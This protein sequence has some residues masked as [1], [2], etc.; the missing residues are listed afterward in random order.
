VTS[1]R[2]DGANNQ[3]R[4]EK[5]AELKADVS[6]KSRDLCGAAPNNKRVE[7][8]GS[9]KKTVVRTA[10]Y[11]TKEANREDAISETPKEGKERG[12]PDP[13]TLGKKCFLHIA[14]GEKRN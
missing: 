4:G 6:S 5:G 7:K 1:T 9:D 11:T 12:T 2:E 13:A 14:E 10:I 3:K 8:K